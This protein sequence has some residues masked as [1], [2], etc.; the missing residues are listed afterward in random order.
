MT[1]QKEGQVGILKER[2]ELGSREQSV[3]KPS[4]E[5]FWETCH[6]GT[7]LRS[8]FGSLFWVACGHLLQVYHWA[9]VA[10]QSLALLAPLVRVWE[11]LWCTL[12]SSNQG[13][14]RR[15]CHIIRWTKPGSQCRQAVFAGVE[16]VG[17]LEMAR[18]L[19][20]RSWWAAG[21]LV[22]LEGETRAGMFREAVA[23][24]WELPQSDHCLG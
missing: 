15:S 1:V 5:V 9:Q 22:A 14:A 20:G 4:L 2:I 7:D 3:S 23:L 17:N 10:N 18:E 19:T 11:G 21:L 6:G 24:P 8:R 12:S 16:D 13:C